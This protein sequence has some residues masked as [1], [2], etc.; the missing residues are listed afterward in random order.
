MKK[1]ITF[2]LVFCFCGML[3]AQQQPSGHRHQR[4]E[5]PKIEEMVSDLSAIQKKRLESATE[6]SRKKIDKL[7]TNL[8]NVRKQ[9]RTLL[10]A[11]GD[12]SEKLFPLYEREGDIQAE[13]SKE[14]YRCR[15]QIDNIL[16]K[17][18]LQ[19]FRAH[20]EKERKQHK[21]VPKR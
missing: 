2:I 5:P 16:T 6:S 21:A 12:Q 19:E 8:S 3:F 4:P 15:I 20:I 17:E 11:E 10:K 9:I 18:Q 14:M 1:S 13:I 7:Q